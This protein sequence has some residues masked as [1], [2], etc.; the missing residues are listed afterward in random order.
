[1]KNE[2]VIKLSFG[3]SGYIANFGLR[4]KA[5]RPYPTKVI[6]R[7][8]VNDNDYQIVW[9]ES[10]YTLDSVNYDTICRKNTNSVVPPTNEHRF[11]IPD[12]KV[13]LN[14]YFNDPNGETDFNY[15]ELS[16]KE[17]RE[18]SKLG[19]YWDDSYGCYRKKK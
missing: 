4:E 8:V 3:I 18:L 14:D 17:W 15:T 12:D 9:R 13:D 7:E 6:Y 10:C 11:S 5:I 2:E 19:I 1:M 16:P